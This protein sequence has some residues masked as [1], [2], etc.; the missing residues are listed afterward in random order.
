[1]S[2]KPYTRKPLQEELREELEHMNLT[3]E[4]LQA[5]SNLVDTRMTPLKAGIKAM[6]LL[7]ENDV[8]P[9][10][11]NIESCYTSTYRRYAQ[12][13]EQQESQESDLYIMK[14]VIREHSEKLKQLSANRL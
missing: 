12:G 2:E 3:M 5:I 13:I 11:Q 6:N 4:D 1:M 9:R 10:L 14:K 7:L 8:L